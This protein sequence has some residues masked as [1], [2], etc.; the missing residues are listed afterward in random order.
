MYRISHSVI[1]PKHQENLH[2]P[3][4]ESDFDKWQRLQKIALLAKQCK[5][6]EPEPEYNYPEHLGWVLN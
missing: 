2:T 4:N 3:Q 6:K 1:P 5:V